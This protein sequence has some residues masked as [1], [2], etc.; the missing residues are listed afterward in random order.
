MVNE[1]CTKRTYF[2][3]ASESF[4]GEISRL[5]YFVD[6]ERENIGSNDNISGLAELISNEFLTHLGRLRKENPNNN[7][8]IYWNIT[9]GGDEWKDSQSNGYVE[10]DSL[11]IPVLFRPLSIQ[12]FSKLYKEAVNLIEKDKK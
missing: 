11:D 8:I 4:D 7:T 6:V 3:W 2:V 1:N 5:S 9:N 10:G 12:E